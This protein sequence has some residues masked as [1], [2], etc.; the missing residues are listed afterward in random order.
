M[1]FACIEGNKDPQHYTNDQG[2]KAKQVLGT[3]Q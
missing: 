3:K 1:E 2:G